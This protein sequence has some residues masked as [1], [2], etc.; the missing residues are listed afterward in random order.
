VTGSILAGT[1]V[2]GAHSAR[3]LDEDMTFVRFQEALVDGE[4]GPVH[5]IVD[6]RLK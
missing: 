2:K 3:V 4:D 6:A 1:T 5:T